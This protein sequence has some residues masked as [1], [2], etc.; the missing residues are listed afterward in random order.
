M[1]RVI[2]IGTIIVK[3]R[4]KGLETN[5]PQT[6][7]LE[8]LNILCSDTDSTLHIFFQLF[9]SITAIYTIPPFFCVPTGP[10]ETHQDSYLQVNKL[11]S[12]IPLIKKKADPGTPPGLL[13]FY[14]GNSFGMLL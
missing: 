2:G 3:V 12:P 4:T 10:L 1:H 7:E 9:I 6:T 5:M 8:L 11:L 14:T 13:R